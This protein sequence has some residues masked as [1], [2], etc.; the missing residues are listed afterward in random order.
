MKNILLS[1]KKFSGIK[2]NPET[3][4]N[5]EQIIGWIKTRRWFPKQNNSTRD[6]SFKIIETMKSERY[7]FIWC[8]IEELYQLYFLPLCFYEKNISDENLNKIF[9]VLTLENNETDE[10]MILHEAEYIQNYWKSLIKVLLKNKKP[11]L[12][13]T[14]DRHKI[15]D[16]I[17][18][19]NFSIE[20]LGTGDTTNIV[21]ALC[22]D[23]NDRILVKSYKKMGRNLEVEVLKR[24][25][26]YGFK[27]CPDYYT[28]L[29]IKNPRGKSANILFREYIT[30][31]KDAGFILWD[32]LRSFVDKKK[33]L[34]VGANSY[35]DQN[36]SN[37]FTDSIHI[38]NL[39]GNITRKLHEILRD[40]HGNDDFFQKVKFTDKK[41]QDELENLKN[42]I[43]SVVQNSHYTKI[44]EEIL[45]SKMQNLSPILRE[46]GR[47]PIHQ[48]LHFGQIILD[49]SNKENLR[50]LD[51]EGDPQL[52][53]KEKYQ[54]F[55]VFQDL[56]SLI[57]ALSYIKYTIIFDRFKADLYEN[58]IQKTQQSFAFTKFVTHI[59]SAKSALN[60]N[61]SAI[62]EDLLQKFAN[63]IGCHYNTEEILKILNKI[64]R[65]DNR[66][67]YS[68]L[69]SFC[70]QWEIK[71]REML[72]EAYFNKDSSKKDAV[73]EINQ[74]LD[75]YILQRTLNELEY[76]KTYR[77]SKQLIP[78]L[79][80][81]EFLF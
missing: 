50:I 60:D 6:L 59:K 41:Y 38:V 61:S 52:S 17:L 22:F 73:K 51:F 12:V 26:T 30:S 32:Q 25:K 31:S 11:K 2:E 64:I 63:S 14:P 10:A 81:I 21:L 16:N 56:A 48:D 71:M 47:Q 77:P 35:L 34:K 28:S 19:N 13:L 43:N 9:G 20:I 1:K 70:D 55:S 4:L 33:Y 37:H 49:N 72:V 3:I 69:V 23:G 36:R 54:K 67:D 53:S 40:S 65:E 46:T 8:V 18:Q 5:H 75:I 15:F 76:E 27:N 39:T 45:F 44:T 79:G 78:L 62:I 80:V 57:R 66:E 74:V 68:K 29:L 42:K 58:K 7:T 24:L